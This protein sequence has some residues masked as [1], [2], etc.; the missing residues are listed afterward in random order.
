MGLDHLRPT[1]QGPVGSRPKAATPGSA[2][3]LFPENTELSTDPRLFHAGERLAELATLDVFRIHPG[4]RAYEARPFG[5]YPGEGPAIPADEL[6]EKFKASLDATRQALARGDRAEGIAGLEGALADINGLGEMDGAQA[7]LH[8][9]FP[10]NAGLKALSDL[11]FCYAELL[12]EE[13][14]QRRLIHNLDLLLENLPNPLKGDRT[15]PDERLLRMFALIYTGRALDRSRTIQEAIKHYEEALEIN[16][17]HTP[18]IEK[19]RLIA[20]AELINLHFKRAYKLS[21]EK[22]TDRFIKHADEIVR[23]RGAIEEK[24]SVDEHRAALI[25]LRQDLAR[26][27]WHLGLVERA[28]GELYGIQSKFGSE[29]GIETLV[30]I[31]KSSGLPENIQNNIIARYSDGNSLR[32]PGDLEELP[33]TAKALL[34]A[35]NSIKNSTRGKTWD[36]VKAWGAG[37]LLGAGAVLAFSAGDASTADLLMGA[38]TGAAIVDGGVR[39]YNGANSPRTREA[40]G[41]GLSAIPATQGFRHAAGF[42][43]NT[44]LPYALMGGQIPGLGSLESLPLIGGLVEPGSALAAGSLYGPGALVTG[45]ID[46]LFHEAALIADVMR[47]GSPL[48]AAASYANH[49]GDSTLGSTLAAAYSTYGNALHSTLDGTLGLRIGTAVQSAIHSDA[50]NVALNGYKGLSLGYY[51]AS[52]F[53]P[54]F[55]EKMNWLGPAFV[56]GGLAI[57]ADLGDALG[58]YPGYVDIGP[59]HDIPANLIGTAGVGALYQI[60]GQTLIGNRGL[61]EVQWFNVLGAA[62]VI[63]GYVGVSSNFDP[64]MR[65]ETLG[66]MIAE[67]VG[68]QIGMLPIIAAHGAM[69]MVDPRRFAEN[70]AAR[71]LFYD[72]F[73]NVTRIA[74]GQWEGFLPVLAGVSIG[75]FGTNSMLGRTFND[76]AGS[77]PA[78]LSFAAMLRNAGGK[79]DEGV[80]RALERSLRRLP[81][82]PQLTKMRPETLTLP[83][84]AFYHSILGKK[85]A[86]Y[87]LPEQ[88]TYAMISDALMADPKNGGL[89]EAQLETLI[90]A[91]ENFLSRPEDAD[92]AR[93]LTYVLSASKTGPH[94]ERIDAFLNRNRDVHARLRIE[95]E[96]GPLPQERGLKEQS[97]FRVLRHP[98]RVCPEQHLDMMEKA[99]ANADQAV[100]ASQLG[101]A[102]M[103]GAG[104]ITGA[105]LM[106]YMTTT[107]MF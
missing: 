30:E 55:R 77:K 51:A 76:L 26:R 47:D 73:G 13:D 92:V 44:L 18:G 57:A 103:M 80:M 96:I 8:S 68:R 3:P 40:V 84:R 107:T 32:A 105:S 12:G 67:S 75:F 83:F 82:A 46:T 27:F 33:L 19:A 4:L 72:H 16:D 88:K 58:A 15:T 41:L 24:L 28:Y 60:L 5:A 70:K 29:K 49:L 61:K 104:I 56:P 7:P 6:L 94:G 91:T 78:A 54:K 90:S 100:L 2:G 85:L 17:L 38:G 36:T 31:V 20:Y 39:L 97:L 43:A 89:N 52:R 69:L 65:S 74:L 64:A 93:G 50:L 62:L 10:E 45:T 86:R 95:R 79:A 87:M 35:S 48:Q 37:A 101:S 63:N 34:W 98:Y 25:I 59:L 11:T 14:D 81:A 1:S 22:K 99:H 23:L 102:S 66:Q 71:L 53:S 9:W 21:S 42:A 106:P